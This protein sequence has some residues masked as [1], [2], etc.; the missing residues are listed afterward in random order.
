MSDSRPRAT[1][2]C[3]G[4]VFSNQTYCPRM[5]CPAMTTEARKPVTLAI[6]QQD[7]TEAG[8]NRG[9]AGSSA[10]IAG[11]KGQW[12]SG[13]ETRSGTAN[14]RNQRPSF[15]E[16]PEYGLTLGRGQRLSRDALF[17]RPLGSEAVSEE[18]LRRRVALPPFRRQR[19]PTLGARPQGRCI[20]LAMTA[21][22][23]DV[24]PGLDGHGLRDHWRVRTC[25]WRSG[26]FDRVRMNA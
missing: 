3:D 20:A 1:P 13:E 5:H 24:P 10:C 7:F 21:P 2:D 23:P 8:R 12:P 9:A 16:P 18:G 15:Y 4:L 11:Q 26:S 22:P 14:R 19:P 25:I 6:P 17:R